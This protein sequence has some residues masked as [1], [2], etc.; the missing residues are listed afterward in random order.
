L[1]LPD[2]SYGL[3]KRSQSF[4]DSPETVKA[5]R[6]ENLYGLWLCFEEKNCLIYE[7][8]GLWMGGRVMQKFN[9][10]LFKLR[11]SNYDT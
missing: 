6:S 7:E 3:H 10:P 9:F 8:L 2:S 5:T 11:D 1:S 4:P